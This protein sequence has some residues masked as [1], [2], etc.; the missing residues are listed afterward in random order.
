M[1]NTEF[2]D[3]GCSS[4]DHLIRFNYDAEDNELFLDVHLFQYRNVFKR[5]WLAIKY[6]FNNSSRY[7]H[8]DVTIIKPEDKGR[9]IAVINKLKDVPA[10][11]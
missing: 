7:G 8:Y 6:V 10:I 2:F 4:F 9:L 5:I 11:K 3:C 1:E